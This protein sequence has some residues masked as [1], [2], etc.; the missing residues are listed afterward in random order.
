MN[1]IEFFGT[2]LQ[3]GI[4]ACDFNKDISENKSM[5]E[6]IDTRS[7]NQQRA[8]QCVII[9]INNGILLP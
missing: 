9:T 8:D 6:I 1:Q 7:E 2:K 3:F 4:D 5:Y